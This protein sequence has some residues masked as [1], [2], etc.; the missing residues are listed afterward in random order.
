VVAARAAGEDGRAGRIGP[1]TEEP[2]GASWAVAPRA[3]YEPQPFWTARR[4][5]LPGPFPSAEAEAPSGDGPWPALPPAPATDG[6]AGDPDPDGSLAR[7][8]L[9]DRQRLDREQRGE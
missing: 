4:S 8:A 1:A 5:V 2:D 3:A 9:A 7:R 6:S